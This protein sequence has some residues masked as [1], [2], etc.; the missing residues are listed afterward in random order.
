ML[1]ITKNSISGSFESSKYKS[2]KFIDKGIKSNVLGKL[3]GLSLLL[4]IFLSFLPWTQ[5]I[6]AKGM[7]TALQPDQ[8]PQTIHSII[9]GRIE[10]WMV[11]EGQFVKRGDTV[12]LLS[13]IKEDYFDPNLVENVEQQIK[14]KELGVKSYMDKVNALDNQID[15][16]I[17]NEILKK[18]ESKNKIEQSRLKVMTDSIDL[19]AEKAN[20]EIAKEQLNRMEELYSE[21]L[22][23]LTDL[24]GKRLKYQE[25]LAKKISQE[26][27]LLS[28]RNELINAK[29]VFNNINNEFADKIAKA[30]SE[31]YASLSAMYDTE[32]QVSKLQNQYVN[33]AIRSGLYYI[34]APQDGYITKAFVNGIGE[35]IKEGQA[36][37]SIMPANA[38]LAVEIF[39]KPMDL[40]LLQK[41][42]KVRLQFDGWPAL[43]FS[44]WEGA[45]F[46]TFG[47]KIVAIDNFTNDK[48]LYRVLVAPDPDEEAWPDAIR[49]GA[50]ALGI[51]MLNNVPIAYEVW[52]QI[53]GFPP[54]YYEAKKDNLSIEEKK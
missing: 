23:S 27:K 11:S 15:A 47:G 29:V 14:A 22:K 10:E 34:I 20:L 28:S 42:Q 24:E 31:K 50:G 44:G 5:N 18:E 49:V 21:G 13:E 54:N 46:G 37:M 53:N 40:P 7:V 8:R 17:Q 39:V 38:D 32:T 48:N 3:S 52:R 26:N 2:L 16:L 41:E 6:S 1:N 45:S 30:E 4:L 43:V 9:P 36:L 12:A 19:I 25:A 35:N 33:Y 51:A